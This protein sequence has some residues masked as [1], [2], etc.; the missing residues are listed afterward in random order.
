MKT[1]ARRRRRSLCLLLPEGQAVP[2]T[3]RKELDLFK[4]TRA[5][6]APTYVIYAVFRT[7][8]NPNS[9]LD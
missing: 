4:V 2:L 3:E 7:D 8:L 9:I 6:T 5:A 1:P